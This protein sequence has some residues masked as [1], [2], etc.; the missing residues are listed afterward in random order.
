MNADKLHNDEP[1]RLVL[2]VRHQLDKH[3]MTQSKLA[4]LTDIRP[5]A[6]SMLARG[7]IE[8][9]NIDHIERI[10]KALNITDIRELIELLPE[11][12]AN[13]YE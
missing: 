1:L 9:I 2:K 10:A 8:R 7:Y 13:K 4:E 11:S 12:Q 5:N 3:E 6:I